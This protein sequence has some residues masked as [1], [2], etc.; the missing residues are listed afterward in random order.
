MVRKP[1]AVIVW[2]TPLES[3]L[4]NKSLVGHWQKRREEDGRRMGG[5]EEREEK[6]GRRRE[7]KSRGRM[8]MGGRDYIHNS[9]KTVPIP[10]SY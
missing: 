9:L 1:S 5:R 6:R 7:E 4:A 8:K 3:A 10:T 2:Y